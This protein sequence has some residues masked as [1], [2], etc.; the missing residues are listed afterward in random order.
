MHHLTYTDRSL[1][2]S[3]RLLEMTGKAVQGK[4]YEHAQSILDMVMPG[5]SAWRYAMRKA[6]FSEPVPGEFRFE[7]RSDVGGRVTGIDNTQAG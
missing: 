7:I 3:G 2:L 5:R 6:A 1:M 4:G